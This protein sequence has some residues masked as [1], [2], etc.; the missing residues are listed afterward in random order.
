MDD[1]S[2]EPTE[3]MEIGSYELLHVRACVY[4]CLALTR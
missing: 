4:L 2:G 1:E 3:L